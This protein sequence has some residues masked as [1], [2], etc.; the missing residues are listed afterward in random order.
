MADSKENYQW[1]LWSDI[2]KSN[3]IQK[4]F[5]HT[6]TSQLVNLF[7]SLHIPQFSTSIP[8][9]SDY[10]LPWSEPISSNHCTFVEKNR[11]GVREKRKN[12]IKGKWK[13]NKKKINVRKAMYP[14]V[15][16]IHI[17]EIS[18]QKQQFLHLHC[19]ILKKE[20]SING[21][22]ILFNRWKEYNFKQKQ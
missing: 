5:N 7:S 4:H 16:S 11:V 20:N 13:S 1:D 2:V 8:R 22:Q 10:L 9:S 3:Q 19:Q 18:K 14:H 17:E 21:Y 15:P 6:V 12:L